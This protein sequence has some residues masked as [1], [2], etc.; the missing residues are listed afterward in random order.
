MSWFKPY[1]TLL[2]GIAVGYFAV[3]FVVKTVRR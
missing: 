3:P 2:V 1:S